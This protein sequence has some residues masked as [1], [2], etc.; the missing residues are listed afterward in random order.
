MGFQGEIAAIKQE[1]AAENYQPLLD[2]AGELGLFIPKIT[3]CRDYEDIYPFEARPLLPV[4]VVSCP[5]RG[6]L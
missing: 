6:G 1:V 4:L 5:P 2:R 3:S